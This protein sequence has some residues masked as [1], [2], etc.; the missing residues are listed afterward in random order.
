MLILFMLCASQI[1]TWNGTTGI[2]FCISFHGFGTVLLQETICFLNR[3][4]FY[5]ASVPSHALGA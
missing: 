3:G 1:K 5:L 2:I 4:K